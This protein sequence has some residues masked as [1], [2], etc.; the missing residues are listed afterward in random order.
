MESFAQSQKQTSKDTGQE[1]VSPA[2]IC[3]EPD[4]QQASEWNCWLGDMWAGLGGRSSGNNHD[5]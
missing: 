5:G 2:L 4:Y 3:S 1:Q